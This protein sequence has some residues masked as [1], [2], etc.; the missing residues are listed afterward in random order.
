YGPWGRDAGR[1]RRRAHRHG[2]GAGRRT[3]IEDHPRAIKGGFVRGV[4]ARCEGSAAPAQ[5]A[6]R[7]AD[8]EGMASTSAPERLP[9][10]ERAARR[11]G[12][13]VVRAAALSFLLVLAVYSS[14]NVSDFGDG[15][16]A[17]PTAHSLLYQRDLDLGEFSGEPFFETHYGTVR[18]GGRCVDYF[19]YL[20]AVF[21]T[22]VVAAWDVLGVAGITTSS[23]GLIRGGRM[24]Q[25]QVLAASTV[26]AAAAVVL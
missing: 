25:L 6:P 10:E 22:P 1:E 12:G 24:R 9:D 4:A 7:G 15:Y 21:G 23:E 17:L 5:G 8:A 18:V 13:G 2:R 20:T 26:T 19:P 14:S 3:T 16:L 11:S